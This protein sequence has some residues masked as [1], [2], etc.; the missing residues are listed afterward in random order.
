MLVRQQVQAENPNGAQVFIHRKPD[1]QWGDAGGANRVGNSFPRET[2][3]T[4]YKR[5]VSQPFVNDAQGRRAAALLR[6][7]VEAVE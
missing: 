7:V 6:R 2:V 3:F 4:E 5:I 1:N